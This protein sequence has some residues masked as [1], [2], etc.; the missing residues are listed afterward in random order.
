M[1]A[2]SGP[3]KSSP[4]KKPATSLNLYALEVFITSGPVTQKFA[5]KNPV[6]SR[7]IEIR[8]DQTLEDLH[9]AIFEAFDRDDNHMYEFQFG[10]TSPDDPRAKRY[11]L[12]ALY[13]NASGLDKLAGDVTQTT[14]DALKLKAG[15]MFGYWFDFGDDWRHQLNVLSITK[16]A[17]K[18]RYPKVIKRVGQS[19][20]QY[21]DLDA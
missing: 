3:K 5:K 19:P 6:M 1:L 21:V 11:S 8:G 20:P 17:T 18:N 4:R 2:K 14:L 16:N 12:S 7:T 13:E 10:G 9:L 15:G